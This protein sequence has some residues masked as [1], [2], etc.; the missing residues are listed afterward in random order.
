MEVDDLEIFSYFVSAKLRSVVSLL[1]LITSSVHIVVDDYT[2]SH[3]VN[4]LLKF[5]Q[6]FTPYAQTGSQF[7]KNCLLTIG[8]LMIKIEQLKVESKYMKLLSNLCGHRDYEV[9][10]YAW[11][12]LTKLSTTLNGAEQMINGTKNCVGQNERVQRLNSFFFLFVAEM[13]NLPGGFHACCLSTLLDDS[14]PAIVRE[15]AAYVFSTLIS[16]RMDNGHLHPHVL[17]MYLEGGE[18]MRMENHLDMLLQHHK[19]F[20][21]IAESLEHFHAGETI[22]GVGMRDGGSDRL[23]SCDLL[24]SF[25]VIMCNLLTLKSIACVDSV[26]LTM[27]KIIT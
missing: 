9:R 13:A 24:R 21:Y 14:E 22:I 3:L 23:T 1:R 11:S 8:N 10:A 20:K 16:Y 26:I 15:N 19:L 27:V 12:I 4:K 5:I 6:T 2:V 18:Q 17:P 7:N 25:C